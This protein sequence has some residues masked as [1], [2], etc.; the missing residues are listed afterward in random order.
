MAAAAKE[1]AAG[2]SV[3]NWDKIPEI[4]GLPTVN[5]SVALWHSRKA[6]AAMLRCI[7]KI[8]LAAALLTVL[9]AC[10]EPSSGS[11][12]PAAGA[13]G[14]EAR[15]VVLRQLLQTQA[16]LWNV[17]API[18]TAG[19]DL[20]RG[21]V[22]PNLGFVAWTRWD[23]GRDYRIASM[24]LYGL[25]HRLRVMHIIAGSPAAQAGLLAGDVIEAVGWHEMPRDDSASAALDQ[26]LDREAVPGARVAFRIRRDREQR[27]IEMVP[28][29]Q[30]D[31][32]LVLTESDQINAFYRGRTLFVTEG[33]MRFIGDDRHVAAV[34]SH[35][36]AHAVLDHVSGEGDVTM[37]RKLMTRLDELR[38]SALREESRDVLAEAGITPGAKPFGLAKEI[39]ADALALDFLARVD[40]PAEALAG[41]W[42]RLNAVEEG[43]VLLRDFHPATPERL[44]AL[45]AQ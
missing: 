27:T 1:E 6:V 11:R 8:T 26:V 42:R 21:R 25:D 15:S 16:R 24:S 3:R 22:R 13:E 41:I 5:V 35:V 44:A 31:F 14:A 2:G 4:L 19:T 7:L 23:I 17:S 40:Y 38:A 10:A 39:E 9:Q 33:L 45:E 18:L 30:C 12:G 43:A 29:L 20:C 37:T 36:L 32:T 34:L 28:R